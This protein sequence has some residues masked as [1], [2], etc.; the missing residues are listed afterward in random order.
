MSL[1]HIKTY[2]YT[3]YL[4]GDDKTLLLARDLLFK[5]SVEV[6]FKK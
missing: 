2:T 4:D 1:V 5:H 6:D 3:I